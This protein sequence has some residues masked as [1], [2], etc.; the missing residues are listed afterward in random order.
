MTRLPYDFQYAPAQPPMPAL[1]DAAL[2]IMDESAIAKREAEQFNLLDAPD[3]PEYAH[4]ELTP[5]DDVSIHVGCVVRYHFSGYGSIEGR[6]LNVST[7]TGRAEIEVRN[8][9]GEWQYWCALNRLTL[10]LCA[11]AAEV[12]SVR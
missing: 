10:L 9:W 12:G 3:M 5:D 2:S 7:E 4:V 1:R 6:V 8:E 11:S